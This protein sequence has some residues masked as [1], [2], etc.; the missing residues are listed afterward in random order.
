MS[1]W[2]S[3]WM[4]QISQNIKSHLKVKGFETDAIPTDGPIVYAVLKGAEGDVKAMKD[5]RKQL[6]KLLQSELDRKVKEYDGFSFKIIP[7]NKGDDLY[8]ACEIVFPSS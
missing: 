1:G 6:E 3:S 5:A 4:Q 8:L 7:S 2:V